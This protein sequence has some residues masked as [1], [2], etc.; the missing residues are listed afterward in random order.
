MSDT[1]YLDKDGNDLSLDWENPDDEN[2]EID[3]LIQTVKD[4]ETK[5]RRLR[6][7]FTDSQI[8]IRKEINSLNNKLYKLCNHNWVREP[9]LYSELYC[10]I[11]NVWKR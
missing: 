2:Y 5:L 8:T 1:K 10:S 9:H 4:K 3:I 11:C 7:Q 6:K